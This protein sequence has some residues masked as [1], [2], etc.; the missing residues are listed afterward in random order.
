MYQFYFISRDNYLAALGDCAVRYKFFNLNL[1]RL[2]FIS[3]DYKFIPLM[4]VNKVS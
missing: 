2:K 4:D 1:A 3:D